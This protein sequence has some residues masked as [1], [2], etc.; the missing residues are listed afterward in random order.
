MLVFTHTSL[1]AEKDGK[2][3]EYEAYPKITEDVGRHAERCDDDS[4]F[5]ACC[6]VF[7]LML[8]RR[9]TE[10]VAFPRIRCSG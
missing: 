7:T 1:T 5:V 6:R 4:P 10:V 8:K 3:D 9:H 2:D